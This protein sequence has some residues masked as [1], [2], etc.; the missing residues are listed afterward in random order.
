[1]FWHAFSRDFFTQVSGSTFDILCAGCR[2]TGHRTIANITISGAGIVGSVVEGGLKTS[3]TIVFDTSFARVIAILSA[4]AA[5]STVARDALAVIGTGA[6]TG[7]NFAS[8]L[9]FAHA[10]TDPVIDCTTIFR[11]GLAS[12]QWRTR[13]SCIKI[14]ANAA[15]RILTLPYGWYIAA[16]VRHAFTISTAAIIIGAA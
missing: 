10:I 2:A 14:A 5:K 9:T 3:V 6:L 11:V 15:I 7:H 12:S 13:V 1:L 4:A 8:V 16:V